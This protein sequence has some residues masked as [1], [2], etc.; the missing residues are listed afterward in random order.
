MTLPGKS[1]DFSV[2]ESMATSLK[3]KFYYRRVTTEEAALQRFEH[4]FHDLINQEVI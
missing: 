3:R 2:L 4:L 1:P